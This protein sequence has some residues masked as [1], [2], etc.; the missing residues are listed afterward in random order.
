MPYAGGGLALSGG[1]G[2]AATAAPANG[3][4]ADTQPRQ[5]E[6]QVA[7]FVGGTWT[8]PFISPINRLPAAGN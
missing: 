7:F 6:D 2:P 3:Q 1:I 8:T 5:D 4:Q